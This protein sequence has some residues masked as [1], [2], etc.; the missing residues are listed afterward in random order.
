MAASTAG[1]PADAGRKRVRLTQ[2]AVVVGG[3]ADIRAALAPVP[4]IEQPSLGFVTSIDQMAALQARARDI[5]RGLSCMYGWMDVLSMGAQSKP[6][7][8]KCVC[9]SKLN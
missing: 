9:G 4:G 8:E 3:D 6:F 1:V 7:G 5:A 2:V